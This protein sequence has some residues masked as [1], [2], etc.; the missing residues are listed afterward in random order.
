MTL[1]VKKKYNFSS[2]LSNKGKNRTWLKKYNIL[3]M[4][5]IFGR[6]VSLKALKRTTFKTASGSVLSILFYIFM[7]FNLFYFIREILDTTNPDIYVSTEF[8]ETSEHINIGKTKQIPGFAIFQTG[9]E[10]VY[11]KTVDQL[12]KYIT[13]EM[14][15]HEI[16]Q[17]AGELIDL[18]KT[19][20]EITECKN[21]R[22]SDSILVALSTSK[23]QQFIQR[24]GKCLNNSADSDLFVYGTNI[25]SKYKFIQINVFPCSLD[26]SECAPVESIIRVVIFFGFIKP[27]INLKMKK[28]PFSFTVDSHSD[29]LI[30]PTLTIFSDITFQQ[31]QIID[32]DRDFFERKVTYQQAIQDDKIITSKFRNFNIHCTK[33]QISTEQC[34]PYQIVRLKASRLKTAH[35]RVYPKII[36]SIGILGGFLQVLIIFFEIVYTVYNRCFKKRFMIRELVGYDSKLVHVIYSSDKYYKENL[37]DLIK[38]VVQEA[39]DSIYV[40]E[41]IHFNHFLEGLFFQ[42]YHK[43]LTPFLILNIQNTKQIRM[44]ESDRLSDKNS[45]KNL[46]ENLSKVY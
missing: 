46:V 30:I 45:E 2:W 14:E 36:E 13:V 22:K 12:S 7:V 3:P 42:D 15:I 38:L 10:G 4:F 23:G 25:D 21:S 27:L 9:F 34:E 37:K 40:A 18:K 6:E 39:Q 33:E 19:K 1:R 28:N 32:D 35:Y 41:K 11:P 5:D 29:Q 8:T 26:P 16:T 24:F 44:N 43:I 17:E 31:N 20:L